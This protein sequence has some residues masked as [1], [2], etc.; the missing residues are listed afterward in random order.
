MNLL[1]RLLSHK[2]CNT[3][4]VLKEQLEYERVVNQELTQ[5]ITGLLKPQPQIVAQVQANT[6]QSVIGRTFS[7]RR[8]ELEKQ[9]KI[10]AETAARSV[11]L[12]KPDKPK[13][14]V[15]ELNEKLEAELGINQ[16]T[17]PQTERI[18]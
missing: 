12:A 17:E 2:P 11:L 1:H 13:D 8:A 9:D 15:S 16:A 14:L 10:T 6:A 18:Q 3:C 4:E 7:R 5:T